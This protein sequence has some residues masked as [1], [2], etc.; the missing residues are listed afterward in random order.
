MDKNKSTTKSIT[1][2]TDL[3]CGYQDMTNRK[4]ELMRK[5]VKHFKS[6]NEIAAGLENMS[7]D[8][9]GDTAVQMGKLA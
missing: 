7:L 1:E 8:D 3:I 2:L 5:A 6:I 9:S 4:N